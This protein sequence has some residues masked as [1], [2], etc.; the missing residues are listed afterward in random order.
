MCALPIVQLSDTASILPGTQ[1]K[2]NPWTV[3]KQ[4][5]KTH[6]AFSH[7]W[8]TVQRGA[9]G[10]GRPLIGRFKCVPSV[11]A[12]VISLMLGKGKQRRSWGKGVHLTG[13]ELE[14]PFFWQ[15]RVFTEMGVATIY[16]PSTSGRYTVTLLY[17]IG[18]LVNSVDQMC[19]LCHGSSTCSLW[20][21]ESIRHTK[22]IP[23]LENGNL[24]V[25]NSRVIVRCTYEPSANILFHF[26]FPQLS[27]CCVQW[28]ASTETK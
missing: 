27:L 7:S 21:Q 25:L 23:H 22:G 1:Q 20:T 11:T 18:T 4:Q 8:C 16:P 14:S 17:D 5:R 2:D 10:A 19:L 15:D 3:R 28:K 12:P 9:R 24:A 13:S 6:W 26:F